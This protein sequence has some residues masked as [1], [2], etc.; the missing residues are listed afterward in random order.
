MRETGLLAGWTAGVRLPAPLLSA[1]W[2]A[3]DPLG[4]LERHWLARLARQGIVVDLDHAVAEA[5]LGIAGPEVDL[6]RLLAA[7]ESSGAG[8]RIISLHAQLVGQHGFVTYFTRRPLALRPAVRGWLVAAARAGGAQVLAVVGGE[9]EMPDDWG[10][11]E[12][13]AL[14]ELPSPVAR[15][16]DVVSLAP[17]SVTQG[18][19]VLALAAFLSSC[20][21]RLD[22]AELALGAFEDEEAARVALLNGTAAQRSAGSPLDRALLRLLE[23]LSEREQALATQLVHSGEALPVFG[24]DVEA[25]VRLTSRGLAEA[26]GGRGGPRVRAASELMRTAIEAHLLEPREAPHALPSS[27]GAWEEQLLRLDR[28]N[29]AMDAV[30]G[31]LPAQRLIQF[32]SAWAEDPLAD[33]VVALVMEHHFLLGGATACLRRARALSLPGPL[34]RGML[35]R[36]TLESG[37]IY[38]SVA[39]LAQ[40]ELGRAPQHRDDDLVLDLA[41][42]SELRE[43]MR[44]GLRAGERGDVRRQAVALGRL[45]R[46]VLRPL[47]TEGR[48]RADVAREA[49]KRR[50][51]RV[52]AGQGMLMAL[53]VGGY[54]SMLE[55]VTDTLV[56]DVRPWLGALAGVNELA[57][58]VDDVARGWHRELRARF[59]RA[60]NHSRAWHHGTVGRAAFVL[61]T[62]TWTGEA[63]LGEDTEGALFR[64][65]RDLLAT[66]MRGLKGDFTAIAS[67]AALPSEGEDART[68][69]AVL[70]ARAVMQTEEPV[71]AAAAL[72]DVHEDMLVIWLANVALILD[73]GR[74]HPT[75]SALLMQAGRGR[76]EAARN[77][78]ALR[79]LVEPCTLTA[80]EIDIE[81]ARLAGEEV[82]TTAARL[83]I[84]ERTVETHRSTAKL[85][86]D[87]LVALGWNPADARRW[88]LEL[89]DLLKPNVVV[90]D[91]S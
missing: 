8:A 5:V 21:Y 51:F 27:P 79:V 68:R 40:Q 26:L 56:A 22:V 75:T 7:E 36:A 1:G 74:A 45:V 23:S 81:R 60:I 70:W 47:E 77:F 80:R 15:V 86:A 18:V 39:S 88:T 58:A 25:M 17:S 11:G 73:P 76:A 64:G 72:A 32:R 87:Q 3:V 2:W 69:S 78:E 67:L 65:K 9:D 61:A 71:A 57:L 63:A 16:G 85:K 19:P 50:L 28:A 12:E 37:E 55:S 46:L 83:G 91:H 62:D 41:P 48:E 66:W 33:L 84:S 49:Y 43:L 42:E 4:V 24:S 14:H 44:A 59:E 29:E 53:G 82:A 20:G 90:N 38:R 6:A 30:A 35:V 54:R 31:R 34:A 89:E 13:S 10:A 52:I